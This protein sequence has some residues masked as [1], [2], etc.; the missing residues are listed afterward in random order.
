MSWSVSKKNY[1]DVELAEFDELS[2]ALTSA[3]EDPPK[4]NLLKLDPTSRSAI[5]S[6]PGA[7]TSSS[8]LEL[9]E[10]H[11]GTGKLNNKRHRLLFTASPNE[12]QQRVED[13]ARSIPYL[14]A[15]HD[16]AFEIA[17]TTQFHEQYN[18]LNDPNNNV[19]VQK[20]FG[21]PGTNVPL[22]EETTWSDSDDNSGSSFSTAIAAALAALILYTI[23]L[24][25]KHDRYALE[26]HDKRVK[27][28]SQQEKDDPEIEA[29]LHCERKDII[30]RIAK[31]DKHLTEAKTFNGMS[32]I[33]GRFYKDN[34]V[35]TT[36]N[37]SIPI[38]TPKLIQGDSST[39]PTF[40]CVEDVRKIVDRLCP[41]I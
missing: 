20:I 33:L 17:S 27:A 14:P 4:V 1:T 23:E 15:S 38:N 28:L 6:L 10:E 40:N 24:V 3:A 36:L 13:E 25:V 12:V 30:Q 34:G 37:R 41:T 2:N 22:P 26:L 11:S 21:F 9:Q 16:K 18:A 39:P 5:G 7:A 29:V 19:K 31:Y 8:T 35:S 32:K